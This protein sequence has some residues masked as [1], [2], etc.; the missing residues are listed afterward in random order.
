MDL[1][2]SLDI[3]GLLESHNQQ[4]AR[5]AGEDKEKKRNLGL[6][7]SSRVEALDNGGHVPE[8]AGVHQG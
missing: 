3:R 1:S 7:C 6:P 8:D 4:S 5:R 2:A